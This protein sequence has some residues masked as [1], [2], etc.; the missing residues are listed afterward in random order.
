MANNVLEKI[1]LETLAKVVVD[2]CDAD[3][4]CDDNLKD[5]FLNGD[6]LKLEQE[7]QNALVNSALSVP[8]NADIT[9][10][11]NYLGSPSSGLNDL[12]PNFNA[13]P[14]TTTTQLSPNTLVP[15]GVLPPGVLP[16]GVTFPGDSPLGGT[17]GITD[18]KPNNK[19]ITNLKSETSTFLKGA[20]IQTK[21]GLFGFFGKKTCYVFTN[22]ADVSQRTS[23]NN[24][25]FP[26]QGL[27]NAEKFKDLKPNY[28]FG[29]TLVAKG[30]G[31]FGP[32]HSEFVAAS[33]ICDNSTFILDA[34][35]GRL[36]AF[37]GI[38]KNEKKVDFLGNDSEIIQKRTFSYERTQIFNELSVNYSQP[39]NFG[40][41][42]E[43]FKITFKQEKFK[44][45]IDL[46][47]KSLLDSFFYGQ[48]F[49]GSIKECGQN[50]NIVYFQT[51]P[52]P[53]ITFD[54]FV[55]CVNSPYSK[56]Q[57]EK[58]QAPANSLQYEIK[59]DYNFYIKFYEE[60]L[61]TTNIQEFE[62]PNLYV[63]MSAKNSDNPSPNANNVYNLGG[64]IH[65]HIKEKIILDD[66]EGQYFDEF[67]KSYPILTN[68]F[69]AQNFSKQK[70][71]IIMPSDLKEM[72]KFNKN[73]TQFP[74]FVNIRFSSDYSNQF[75][76]ILKSAKLLDK[77]YAK[78]CD[79]IIQNTS[80]N[81]TEFI[82]DVED[83]ETENEISNAGVS[84]EKNL[85]S[86]KYF[87][88]L[89]ILAEIRED[90][91]ND[92]LNLDVS[93][94]VGD[95]S[96]FEKMKKTEQKEFVDSL[97]YSI[98]KNKTVKFLEQTTRSFKNILSGNGCYN[99]TLMYRIAKYRGT[100]TNSVP[101]Q[102]IFLPNESELEVIEYI[103]TQVKYDEEYTY[104]VYAYQVVVGNTYRYSSRLDG[105]SDEEKVIEVE[106]RPRILLVETPFIINSARV[107]DSPPSPPEVQII[108]Y[109]DDPEKVLMMLNSSV[110]TYMSLPQILQDSDIKIYEKVSKLQEKNF[111][112]QIEFSTDDRIAFYQVFKLEEKPAN[113]SDFSNN[114]AYTV[115]TDISAASI[116]QASSA[117][118][119]DVIRPG[120]KFYYTF[121]AIDVHGKPS[122]PSPVFEIEMIN[123]NGLIFMRKKTIELDVE[124]PKIMTIPIRRFLRLQPA[125]QHTVINED[126]KFKQAKTAKEAIQTM[127]LGKVDNPIWGK[128]FKLRVV[129][130]QTKKIIDIK[131]K[132][133]LLKKN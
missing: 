34:F 55:F 71:I 69:K 66:Y 59:S 7:I 133:D 115:T 11:P 105:S 4:L 78:V 107:Y 28:G 74:M 96:R 94:P 9:K 19:N 95:I 16:P 46:F 80:I 100:D 23:P 109:K 88:L 44:D 65:T 45:G 118:V 17:F 27:I 39:N 91:E 86:L 76:Y 68:S 129:S 106:N 79:K 72:M 12:G 51:V 53:Q 41:L 60:L 81:Q 22:V 3:S 26:I 57:L 56:K 25:N 40:K 131:F 1:D 89:Q 43:Q 52:D 77:T 20:G 83:I 61:S 93:L 75:S 48:A 87:D 112:E 104:A 99:E 119:I 73:K 85:L 124:E 103:D 98:F 116:Q 49:D 84:T 58:A 5:I 111:G 13:G 130:K 47:S 37:W 15:P 102:N 67:S 82:A 21:L 42:R 97:Y 2:Q 126:E 114:L 64:L 31:I 14:S 54:D 30:P 113:Y 24:S 128:Q 101:I 18:E 29:Q 10:N 117:A 123:E 110:N 132:F 121:R 120:I 6:N 50:Y 125:F 127:K 32:T 90:K 8:I 92:L 38:G 70:N 35:R 33:P 122:N 36:G 63:L 108:S 62:L